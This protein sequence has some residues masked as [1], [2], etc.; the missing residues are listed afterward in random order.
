MSDAEADTK[1]MWT[2][3]D[4]TKP[5]SPNVAPPRVAASVRHLLCRRSTNAPMAPAPRVSASARTQAV[6]W[7]RK[8]NSRVL[9][10]RA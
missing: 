2:I 8:T 7:G 3:C 9:G 1:S 6:R 5:P 10:S 4:E